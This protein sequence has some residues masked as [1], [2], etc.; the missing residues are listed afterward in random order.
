MSWVT[1]T[2]SSSLGRK[3]IMAITGLSLVAFLLVHCGINACIFL[4]DGGETFNEAAEFMAKNFFIRT[5]EIGLFVGLIA[6]IIDGLMLWSA[7]KKKRP[8]QYAV[9]S[10]DNSTWYS[11]SM[12]LLGTLLLLFLVMHL[13]HFWVVSRFTDVITGGQKTL[14]QEMQEV[15]ASPV[16]VIVYVVGCISLAYHLL[17]GVQSAFQSLGWNHPKYTPFVKSFGCWFAIIIPVVFAAM[18]IAMHLGLIK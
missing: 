10:K 7:N 15:F 1:K 13:K 4:N 11:R 14:F 5:A 6:H 3:L 18:P 2:L 8:V 17:H 9:V 12:G 16:P